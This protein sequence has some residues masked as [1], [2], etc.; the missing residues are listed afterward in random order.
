MTDFTGYWR[1]VVV[2]T[3]LSVTR[4]NIDK[5]GRNP[6]WKIS[7]TMDVEP[8]NPTLLPSGYEITSN[9]FWSVKSNDLNRMNQDEPKPGDRLKVTGQADGVSPKSFGVKGLEHL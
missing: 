5:S 7:F 2:G 4:E 1:I 3:V 9:V 8:P 6:K